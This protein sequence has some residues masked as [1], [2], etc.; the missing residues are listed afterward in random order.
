MRRRTGWWWCGGG[1]SRGRE[2]PLHS[3]G[4]SS[5]K[6]RARRRNVVSARSPRARRHVVSVPST[7][8]G[9]LAF[10]VPPRSTAKLPRGPLPGGSF[11]HAGSRD[12]RLTED[13]VFVRGIAGRTWTP[14][15]AIP[16]S[17]DFSP[18]PF[19][20]RARARARARETRRNGRAWYGPRHRRWFHAARSGTPA[21][22]TL[23]RHSSFVIRHSFVIGYSVIR[24][25][26]RTPNTLYL[27]T[28]TDPARPRST[29]S[30]PMP[31]TSA[32][33]RSRSV[34]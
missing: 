13:L 31:S 5:L 22:A 17:V 18:I 6:G 24:H 34:G 32:A 4:R 7:R 23:L 10:Q 12:C 9:R 27:G 28:A 14:T 30:A 25:W 15:A 33:R 16:P 3:F 1:S 21:S 26:R 19:R 8:L 11:H 20:A 2:S 29:S